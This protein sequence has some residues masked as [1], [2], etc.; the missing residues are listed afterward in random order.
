MRFKIV[1]ADEDTRQR[2][3]LKNYQMGFI[4]FVLIRGLL[5]FALPMF[6]FF[7][8]YTFL[9]IG[10]HKALLASQLL[11]TGT[12]CLIEGFLFGIWMWFGT[13]RRLRRSSQA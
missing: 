8:L 6:V 4:R 1:I 9:L 5:R 10:D 11:V 13:V 2:I 7:T 3:A 12:I